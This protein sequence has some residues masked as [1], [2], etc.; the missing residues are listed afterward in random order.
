MGDTNEK[1]V[2]EWKREKQTGDII[3][4]KEKIK[5]KQKRKQNW[6]KV[7]ERKKNGMKQL[8]KG[9]KAYIIFFFWL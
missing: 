3:C 8:K 1:L 4:N 6:E 2:R 7:T 5:E 9:K